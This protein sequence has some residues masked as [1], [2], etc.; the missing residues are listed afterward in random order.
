MAVMSLSSS[1]EQGRNQSSMQ[2]AESV[3]NSV[4]TAVAGGIYTTLLLVPPQ[5]LAYSA[6]LALLT[7]A[8]V[9]AIVVSR[10]IGFLPNELHRPAG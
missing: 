10:R 4:V 1:F 2:V 7:V 6:P 5:K 9:A 3:G 8:S